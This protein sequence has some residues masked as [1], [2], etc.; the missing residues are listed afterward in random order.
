M[1]RVLLQG[2]DH[3][4]TGAIAD[5]GEPR[6]AVASEVTLQDAPVLGSV[7]KG[8]PL[9]ELEHARRRFLGVQLR[10]APVVE[11]LAAAHRVA[12]VH[13]P[14]VLGVHVAERGGDAAF[15]HHRVRLAEERFAHES[16]LGALRR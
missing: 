11:H 2:A 14:V 15:G 1:D 7:E 13:L 3:F 16:R 12:K 6:V 10:H 8:A 5:V 4:E 9:F